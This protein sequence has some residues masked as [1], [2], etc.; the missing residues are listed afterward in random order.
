M[1][2]YLKAAMQAQVAGRPSVPQLF[3]LQFVTHSVVLKSINTNNFVEHS[4][5]TI[6]RGGHSKGQAQ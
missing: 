3:G 2:V 5:L 6:E 4:V 1:V